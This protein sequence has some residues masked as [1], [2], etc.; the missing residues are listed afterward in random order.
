M[1]R[2]PA[3]GCPVD[4]A[5]GRRAGAAAAAARRAGS[6]VRRRSARTRRTARAR[7]NGTVSFHAQDDTQWSPAEANYPVTSGNA[8]WTEPNAQAEIEVS[9]SRIAMAPGTELDITTL[10]DTALQVDRTAG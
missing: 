4:A 2:P 6:A 7:L 3:W 10:D 8:F 5:A 1:A 9:A